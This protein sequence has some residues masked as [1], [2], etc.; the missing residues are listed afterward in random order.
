MSDPTPYGFDLASA[1]DYN[2]RK[3]KSIGWY[4]AIPEAALNVHPCW[5]HDAVDGSLEEQ[6]RFAQET[7]LFQINTFEDT[8]EHDGKM[9]SGTWTKVLQKFDPV[10]EN[11]FYI[12]WNGRRYPTAA[13]HILGWDDPSSGFDLHPAGNFSKRKSDIR[14]IVIHWGGSNVKNLFNYFDNPSRDLS[15]HFGVDPHGAFQMLDLQ[16]RAWHAGYVNKYAVGIDICQQPTWDY[17]DYY[18]SPGYK[19]EKIKNPTDRGRDE[20]LSLDPQTARHTRDLVMELCHVLDIP[21]RAPRGANGLSQEGKVWHGVFDKST[22]NDGHF[23]GVVG[24]HHISSGKF[25][26]ACWWDTVFGGTPLG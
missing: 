16:H 23:S 14:I 5:R 1:V 22:L 10:T 20:V 13:P 24:H 17:Y 15:T 19:V 8:S 3:A 18:Q 9:G 4:N 12:T 25:D 2:Q 11:E 21:A 26:M 7:L 6:E